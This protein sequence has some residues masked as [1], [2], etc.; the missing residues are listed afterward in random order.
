MSASDN[1]YVDQVRERLEKAAFASGNFPQ[2]KWSCPP[3]GQHGFVSFSLYEYGDV[4]NAYRRCFHKELQKRGYGSGIKEKMRSAAWQK[5][6]EQ[7]AARMTVCS[8]AD[9]KAGQEI[10]LT[11]LFGHGPREARLLEVDLEEGVLMIDVHETNGH[12]NDIGSAYIHEVVTV[13]TD[14]GWR[15]FDLTEDERKFKA[16]VDKVMRG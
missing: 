13:E 14:Q 16:E 12:Y 8:S 10:T 11:G 1:K 3:E 5:V 4:M 7:I 9:L 2:V 15:P 6:V